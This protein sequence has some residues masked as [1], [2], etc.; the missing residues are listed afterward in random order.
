MSDIYKERS[1]GQSDVGFSG[2][3]GIVVVDFQKGFIDPEYPMG[4]ADLICLL[5]TS[6]SPRD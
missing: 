6:P 1:Y 3:P 2:K 5:Y 4:G